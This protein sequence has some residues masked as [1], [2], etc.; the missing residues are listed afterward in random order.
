MVGDACRGHLSVALRE[1]PRA[2]ALSGHAAARPAHAGRAAPRRRTP[3]AR[4]A[5]PRGRGPHAGRVAPHGWGHGGTRPPHAGRVAPQGRIETPRRSAGRRPPSTPLLEQT[6]SGP[7]PA[8][9]PRLRSTRTPTIPRVDRRR[10]LLLR[11]GPPCVH[12]RRWISIRPLRGLLDQH[13]GALRR[14][15]LSMKGPKARADQHEG[16]L[17]RGLLDQRAAGARPVLDRQGRRS[18]RGRQS[19]GVAASQVGRA[20]VSPESMP[21]RAARASSRVATL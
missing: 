10:G 6:R 3:R 1:R 2:S 16:A 5:A 18:R 7:R 8:R 20:A 14:G 13:G 11:Q 17:R 4:R 15:L 19:I 9:R 21:R 12:S